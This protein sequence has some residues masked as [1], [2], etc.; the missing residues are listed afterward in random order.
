MHQDS[1]RKLERT[2]LLKKSEEVLKNLD[3]L[4]FYQ[5]LNSY[6]EIDNNYNSHFIALIHNA[7]AKMELD[8]D[9]DTWESMVRLGK[10]LHELLKEK[11]FLNLCFE[12]GLLHSLADLAHHLSPLTSSLFTQLVKAIMDDL[13]YSFVEEHHIDILSLGA[14]RDL[15]VFLFWLYYPQIL[16]SRPKPS[17][18]PIVNALICWN[19]ELGLVGSEEFVP[20]VVATGL[21]YLEVETYSKLVYSEG[22]LGAALREKLVDGKIRMEIREE[23][24]ETM[25]GK[26][27]RMYVQYVLQEIQQLTKI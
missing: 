6:S 22:G 1:P 25:F 17:S 4:K 8:S 27:A 24:D 15:K 9:N 5:I 23:L 12:D 3:R 14:T 7:F 19:L 10:I 26:D 11:L 2:I 20:K 16:A 21:G 13:P 18:S